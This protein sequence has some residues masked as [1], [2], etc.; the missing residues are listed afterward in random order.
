MLTD[1][2][3]PLWPFIGIIVEAIVVAVIICG[4]EF[5][6]S[7]RNTKTGRATNAASLRVKKSIRDKNTTFFIAFDSTRFAWTLVLRNN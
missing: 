5:Y 6:R 1:P 7:K 2:L 3:A 4:S